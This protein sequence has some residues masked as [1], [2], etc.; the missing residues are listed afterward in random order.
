MD[1][2]YLCDGKYCP[3]VMCEGEGSTHYYADNRSLYFECRH[4]LNKDF[5]KNG[6]IKGP[7]DLIKRFKL[8]FK[9]HLYLIERD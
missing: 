9:P 2:L 1:V 8:H 3:G 5:A 6:P 4:T 7:I